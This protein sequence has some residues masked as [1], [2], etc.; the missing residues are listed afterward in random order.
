MI[1]APIRALLQRLGPY[2]E[3]ATPII[4]RPGQELAADEAAR[5]AEIA[6]AP[7]EFALEPDATFAEL[8]SVEQML[9]DPSQAEEILDVFI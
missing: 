1:V 8:S 2:R 4:V 6:P 9:G 5:A 3:S 7:P